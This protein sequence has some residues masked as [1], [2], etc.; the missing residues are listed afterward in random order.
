MMGFCTSDNE[1]DELLILFPYFVVTTPSLTLVL[2]P[3]AESYPH[4]RSQKGIL[5]V[6][7]DLNCLILIKAS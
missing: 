6:L 5:T 4:L 7:T 3:R 2:R 1:K